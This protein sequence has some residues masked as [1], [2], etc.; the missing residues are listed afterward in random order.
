MKLIIKA[1]IDTHN[2]ILYNIDTKYIYNR[3]LIKNMI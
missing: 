2:E 1:Y 3:L